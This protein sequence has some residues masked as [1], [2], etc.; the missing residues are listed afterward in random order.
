MPASQSRDRSTR[1]RVVSVKK[2]S[3]KRREKPMDL[4][5]PLL[6]DE[7]KLGDLVQKM[8]NTPPLPLEKVMRRRNPERDPKYLPVFPEMETAKKKSRS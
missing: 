4:P 5:N 8:V 6:V 7:D 3:H 2:K 1:G